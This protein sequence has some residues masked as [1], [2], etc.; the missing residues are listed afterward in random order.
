MILK[1]LFN[2]RMIWMIFI[3]IL[4][5]TIRIKK[6]KIDCIQILTIWLL[7]WLVPGIIRL[8]LTYYFIMEIQNKQELQRATFNGSSDIDFQDFINLYTKCAAN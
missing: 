5:N 6:E 3:E 1:L 2:T 4:K 8:I 7:I